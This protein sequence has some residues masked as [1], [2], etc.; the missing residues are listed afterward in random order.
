[1][2]Q[3]TDLNQYPYWD[4]FSES[5]NFYRI[6]FKP[7]NAV[8]GRELNQLQ[9]I[10]QNQIE[11]FGKHIFEPDTR[12]L[13]GEIDFDTK[14]RW[15]NV[16]T[17]SNSNLTSAS[18]REAN[19]HNKIIVRDPESDIRALVLTSSDPDSD[20]R[21]KLYLKYLSSGGDNSDVSVYENSDIVIVEDT[22]ISMTLSSTSSSGVG[23]S[24]SIKGGVYFV[25][26][27]FVRVEDQ[28]IILEESSQTP[29]YRVGLEVLEELIDSS[30]DTSL[31]S[32]AQGT[33]NY[34]G[35][36]A[37]RLKISLTLVKLT[38]SSEDD[39]NFIELL[40][41]ESGEAKLKKTH[42][43][44]SR[45]GDEFARRTYDESGDY[46]TKP[47]LIEMKDHETDDTKL[48]VSIEPGKGY[49]RGYEIE[50]IG[51]TTVDLDKARDTAR[52]NNKTIRTPVGNYCI[53][54]NVYKLP[55][56]STYISVNLRDTPTASRGTGA[57]SV[58]G[59]AK[60][61][62][63]MYHSG[64]VGTT[65]G[66]R[67]AVYRVYLFDITM[68][69]GYSFEQVKQVHDSSASFT[70][71][72][73]L[74]EILLEGAITTTGATA[75]ITGAGTFWVSKD[76]QKLVTG[77]YIRVVPTGALIKVSTITNDNSITS[78]DPVDPTDFTGVSH[79]YVYAE[80][81]ESSNN[82]LVFPVPNNLIKTIRDSVGVVDT[83]YETFRIFTGN[84]VATDKITLT[85]SSGEEFVSF[86]NEDYVVTV[87]TVGGG[88]NAVGDILTITSGQV[89]FPSSTTVEINGLSNGNVLTVL[90]TVRKTGGSAS[91]EKTKTLQVSATDTS[92]SGVQDLKSFSLTKADIYQIRSIYMAPDFTTVPTTSHTNITDRYTLDNGQKDNYYGLGRIVLNDSAAAPTGR[93]L[94]TYDYFSHS[95]SGTYFSVNSYSINY[96]DI[97]NYLSP[98]TGE[99]YELRDCLDFRPTVNSTGTAF[100]NATGSLT[101][102]PKG[103]VSADYEYYLNRI[104][105]LY[106]D[107]KGN[108]HIIKGNSAI[109][110][111]EPNDPD[112]GMIIYKLMVRAYTLDTDEVFREFIENKR[113]TMR[114][115]GKLETR[116]DNLEYYTALSLLE[117]ETADFQIL[118]ASGFDRYKNGFMVDP[119]LGHAVGDVENSGYKCSIDMIKGQLRPQFYEDLVELEEINST[120]IARLADHYQKTGDLITLPYSTSAMV[121]QLIASSYLNVNP[122]AVFSFLGTIG[123]NPPNDEWKDTTTLPD[124]I[125][126]QEGNYDAMVSVANAF[127][128]T[129]NEWET[130]WLGSTTTKTKTRKIIKRGD[131]TNDKVHSRKW[132]ALRETTTRITETKS[133]VTT[134]SGDKLTVVPKTVETNLG[135]RVVSVAYIPFIRSRDVEIRGKGFKPNSRLYPYFDGESVAAHMTAW[136]DPDVA[137]VFDGGDIVSTGTKLIT[138]ARGHVG[139][140][141]RIPNSDSLRFKTGERVVRFTDSS[142]NDE[143][144]STSGE[145]Y[146]RAQGLLE[147]KQKTILSTRNAELVP[148]VVTQS[149]VVTSTTTDVQRTTKWID[150][151]AQSFLITK[152]G[153]AFISS[154][155]L[156]FAT[157][158]DNIP[159]IVELRE[160][161]NGS[162][163]QRV[164]PFGRTY[165]EAADVHT[166][167]VS[168]GVLSIDGVESVLD[169]VSTNFTATTA[170]FESPVY[171]QEGYEYAVVVMANSNNYNIWRAVLGQNKIG[172]EFPVVEQP[173]AGSLFKSQNASTWTPEQESDL[174]LRINHCVFDT[175]TTGQV[176]FHNAI[177][178]SDTLET[179]PFET[180]N[181]SNIVRIY[182]PNHGMPVGS[183]V[184]ISGATGTM[185]NIPA[186]EF[187]GNEV[188][189]NVELDSYT[190]TTTTSANASGRTGGTTIVVAKNVPFS[191]LRPIIGEIILPETQIIYGIKTTSGKSVHGS[192]S[193]YSTDSS[194]VNTTSNQN[195]EFD[196][197]RL[198]GSQ[199]NETTSLSG[200]KSLFFRASLV[201]ENVNISPVIDLSRTSVVTVTNR[202]DDPYGT[203]STNNINVTAIDKTTLVTNSSNVAFDSTTKKITNNN[204]A[205]ALALSVIKP[206]HY[207]EV[208]DASNSG[209]NAVMLVKSVVHTEGVSTVIEV[210]NSLTT[211]AAG[212]STTIDIAH[213]DHFV[214]EIAP[215]E[216]SASARYICRRMLLTNPANAL[217]IAYTA[218]RPSTAT[219]E[220]YY[221]LLPA[222]NT[223][224]FDDLIWIQSTVDETVP[225]SDNSDDF[226]EYVHTEEL[227]GDFSGVAV[228]LVLRGSN[229]AQPPIV[230]DL[231]TIAYTA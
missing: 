14:L 161:I 98:E 42:T 212:A 198:I 202:L 82:K 111:M 211:E 117:K 166:N 108:F 136:A 230:E 133:G 173:Y 231:K 138:D 41:L 72:I 73:Y 135:E 80:L 158:D 23:S 145:S 79:A 120:D 137:E 225:V 8:Q 190:I 171:L 58:I 157:K 2:P 191:V 228:K 47:W 24:A 205:Q 155:D 227:L 28:L 223:S 195:I 142:T 216:G 46:T 3:N 56:I 119:F 128:T 100:D 57:G 81:F 95:V 188:I 197:P 187:N 48:V 63:I 17:G 192:Q 83:S 99:R 64:D 170:T 6:L 207:I 132:P 74:S 203:G 151:L 134:R 71:D 103:D 168:S 165:I 89:S 32:N 160:M 156:W 22:S 184:T 45:L 218:M 204:A 153:G 51:K 21:V 102:I 77:D 130:N 112:D 124:L 167:V 29:S 126:N 88:A 189:A 50:T 67:G 1:M 53:V 152:K 91:Q 105:K 12:V 26:G 148:E 175:S 210:S 178:E 107:Y 196:S 201:S 15:I 27:Y 7:R 127:G 150:P 38:P 177:L 109:V 141:L 39:A 86:A 11:R 220:L 186:A 62:A 144:F 221:K 43:D 140:T 92:G 34:A 5:K 115:I 162:P 174:M 85:A 182:H 101:H 164:I 200:N 19:L 180:S 84:T 181:G 16:T 49:V 214:S 121:E 179:S 20:N 229:D 208:T 146:Y 194:Y 149:K 94:V 122:Y 104:D 90:A 147:T 129:W 215:V 33:P 31:L 40:I 213:Y 60:V 4:N 114:D 199:I 9:A 61:R 78:A 76:S 13:G 185:N 96:E 176:E 70:A 143:N 93:L 87:T 37:D 68:S 69:A 193:A 65:S 183:T 154:V 123:L 169:P 75:T 224:N 131:N 66:D 44:Y 25:R 110:P 159:V 163:G 35:P 206:G 55:D 209:N 54:D 125:V 10:I 30:E 118:D 172:T 18:W 36:G 97:P 139:A 59:T 52:E 217:K 226:R 222:G 116:I 106:I 113:Y 219:I